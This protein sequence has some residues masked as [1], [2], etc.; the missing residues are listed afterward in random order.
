MRRPFGIGHQLFTLGATNGTA[1]PAGH[2]GHHGN[3]D[4]FCM[5]DGGS[6]GDWSVHD[7]WNGYVYPT[8]LRGQVKNR[9]DRQSTV[10]CFMCC[11]K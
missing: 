9:G 4:R 11:Q 5:D 2:Q 6:N 7:N 3:M 10:R 8:I 1:R